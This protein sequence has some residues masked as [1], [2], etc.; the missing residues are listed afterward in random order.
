MKVRV[1]KCPLPFT[2][3]ILNQNFQESIAGLFLVYALIQ[4]QPY[5]GFACLRIIPDDLPSINRIEVVARRERRLDVLYILG[6]VL[7]TSS[8]Y[9]AAQRER[10][11]EAVLR[12]YLE[13][14]RMFVFFCEF[15]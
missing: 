12:K 14:N 4:L 13:G 9:H 1:D 15:Y 3:I 8:Q 6:D 7:I 10:G 11:F 5:R 2:F